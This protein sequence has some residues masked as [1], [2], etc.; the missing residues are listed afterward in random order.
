MAFNFTVETNNEIEDEIDSISESI[1]NNNIKSQTIKT[2]NIETEEIKTDNQITSDYTETFETDDEDTRQSSSR[3]IS[4]RLK[5]KRNELSENVI[6]E[7]SDENDYSDTFE[8]YKSRSSSYTSRSEDNTKSSKTGFVLKSNKYTETFCSSSSS[9]SDYESRTFNTDKPLTLAELTKKIRKKLK[10]KSQKQKKQ[11]TNDY[12]HELIEKIIDNLKTSIKKPKID[13]NSEYDKYSNIEIKEELMNRLS[14]E[15]FLNDTKLDYIKKIDIFGKKLVCESF[16]KQNHEIDIKKMREEMYY[17]NK[18][19]LVK[20]KSIAD[21]IDYHEN[22]YVDSIN[23]IGNLASGL[24][25]PTTHSEDI[26]KML[27]KPLNKQIN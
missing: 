4:K 22:Y 15:K 18:C 12:P 19:D 2:V 23:L 7:E 16:P 5:S 9:S 13:I 17:K 11:D 1:I 20:F 6:N 24:P 3:N 27:L 25:K 21:K 10:T 26:W 14:L 8:D